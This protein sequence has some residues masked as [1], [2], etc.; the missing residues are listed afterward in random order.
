M[1]FISWEIENNKPA[2]KVYWPEWHQKMQG[3]CSCVSNHKN[4]GLALYI[5]IYNTDNTYF[6]G[7]SLLTKCFTWRAK[8]ETFADDVAEKKATL[9]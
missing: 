7:L 4:P 3:I 5:A 1:S 8:W 6:L 9:C 2:A